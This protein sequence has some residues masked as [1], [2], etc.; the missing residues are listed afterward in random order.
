MSFPIGCRQC[1][2]PQEESLAFCLSGR[3]SKI[4]KV[5]LPGHITASAL[6]LGVCE[7][8]YVPFERGMSL[9]C[10][11]LALLCAVLLA[12]KARHTGHSSPQC[13]TPRLG[14]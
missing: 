6:A 9:S 7:V 12:F 8:L 13:E 2:F 1:L 4:S 14:S 5:V 10:I 11:S 3:L